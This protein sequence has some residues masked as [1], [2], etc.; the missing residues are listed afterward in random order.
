M[1]QR[2]CASHEVRPALISMTFDPRRPRPVALSAG[3]G[4]RTAAADY[5]A[6]LRSIREGCIHEDDY[7]LWVK[8]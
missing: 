4:I 7:L 8:L 1:S 3:A 5:G 6:G 2:A